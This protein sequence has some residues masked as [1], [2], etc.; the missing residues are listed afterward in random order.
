VSSPNAISICGVSGRPVTRFFLAIADLEN[1][2]G[3]DFENALRAMDKINRYQ[4]R[5]FSKRR[6]AMSKSKD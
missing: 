1:A 2:S 4:R 6:R 5:A 3:H